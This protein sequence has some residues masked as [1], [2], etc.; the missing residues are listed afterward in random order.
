MFVQNAIKKLG[1]ISITRQLFRTNVTW[2]QS[3]VKTRSRFIKCTSKFLIS[4]L[5]EISLF[6]LSA[7]E[8]CPRWYWTLCCLLELKLNIL[9]ATGDGEQ[10]TIL[11]NYF[12][13]LNKSHFEINLLLAMVSVNGQQSWKRCQKRFQF[14]WSVLA[15]AQLHNP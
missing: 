14:S 8:S 1:T 6:A 11:M 13:I 7:T 5:R 4:S 10:L 3:A 12:H 15:I 9:P 2:L